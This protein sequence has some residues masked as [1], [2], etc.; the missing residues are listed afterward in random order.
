MTRFLPAAG[1]LAVVL[2]LPAQSSSAQSGGGFGGGRDARRAEYPPSQGGGN[3]GPPPAPPI[4]T[5]VALEHA[6]D[7]NLTDAQR[8]SI[9]V[10]RTSQDSANAP[11]RA[12]LDSL[13]PTRLPAGGPNDMS[14]DQKDEME[15]RQKQVQLVMQ[16]FQA[17][18]ESSRDKVLAVLNP[19]QQK[20]MKELDE[21]A[22]K[23]F[24]DDM[25]KRARD[26]QDRGGN[27]GGGRR[28]QEN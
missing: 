4:V 25:R 8:A 20:R 24:E 3:F 15:A 26:N 16:G 17:S 23:K 13:R 14:Q 28:P 7:L 11:L 9:E 5:A 21:E 18:N 27:R 6:K 12:R 10:L 19:D 22:T 2:S 1:L